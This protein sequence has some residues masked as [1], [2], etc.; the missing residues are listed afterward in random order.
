MWLGLMILT[1]MILYLMF[2]VI[3]TE[4][5]TKFRRKMN[6]ADFNLSCWGTYLSVPRLPQNIWSSQPSI[7][8]QTE[9]PPSPGAPQM[10]QPGLIGPDKLHFQAV[11]TS[12]SGSS[13]PPMPA[14]ISM[15][16]VINLIRWFIVAKGR[17]FSFSTSS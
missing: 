5:R 8:K 3:I 14:N 4:W 6:T 13:S 15:A 10:N 2:T 12:Q 16:A 1:T 11:S 7:V 9:H 17:F